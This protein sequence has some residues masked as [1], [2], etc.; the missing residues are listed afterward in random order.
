[1]P[2]IVYDFWG[3]IGF[4]PILLMD[5]LL[6]LIRIK[7]TSLIYSLMNSAGTAFII[8][9]FVFEFNFHHI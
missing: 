4:S 2:F 7:S 9:S 5:S 3:T 6:Q 1:M 8:L